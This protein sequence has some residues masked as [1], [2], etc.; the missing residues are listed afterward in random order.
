MSARSRLGD[1]IRTSRDRTGLTQ[2][3]LG[4]K[5]GV[6][7]PQVSRWERG[8]QRPGGDT[9]GPLAEA[10]GLDFRDLYQLTLDA[11]N[12]EVKQ[13]RR[14]LTDALA[15]ARHDLQDALTQVNRFVDTYEAFHAAYRQMGEQMDALVADVA[16]IKLKLAGRPPA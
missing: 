2:I 15:Q 13:T 11:G 8:L 7:G 14:E 10:L 16:E 5:V 4:V 6:S 1:L 9:I 3:E 12:E